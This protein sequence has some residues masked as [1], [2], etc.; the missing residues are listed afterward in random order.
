MSNRPSDLE[1]EIRDYIGNLEDSSM[2]ALAES[3]NIVRAHQSL[4]ILMAKRLS[5]GSYDGAIIL[6]ASPELIDLIDEIQDRSE[7]VSK[8]AGQMRDQLRGLVEIL[9]R[10]TRKKKKSLNQRIFG[11]L[12]K[13]FK[14]VAGVLSALAAAS[15]VVF[16][17]AAPA[18]AAGSAL[19]SAASSIASDFESMFFLRV[20]YSRIDSTASS[21]GSV[22]SFDK[23]LAMLS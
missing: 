1:V 5:S 9:E 3:E 23:L 11:W 7:S 15:L 2:S 10:G 19:A 8:Y 4:G 22:T 17:I 6:R 12:R 16:H 13:I 14:V 18:L 20:A 21:G